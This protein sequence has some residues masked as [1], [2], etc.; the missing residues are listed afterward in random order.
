[1]VSVVEFAQI[2]Q[3]ISPKLRVSL[4]ADASGRTVVKSRIQSVLIVTKARDNR[5]IKLTR[6]LAVYLMSKRTSTS[7]SDRPGSA[8]STASTATASGTNN[9]Y[10][11]NGSS[12]DRGLIVYVDAQL[13]KSKRFNAAGIKEEHPE[14]F[15]PTVRRRSS[16]STSI[17][18]ISAAAS[19]ASLGDLHRKR[20][21]MGEEGQLRYWTGEM[22]SSQPHLFDFVIT[23]GGDGTVLFTSWLLCVPCPSSLLSVVLLTLRH[24]G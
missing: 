16:S 15:R 11:G 6:E 5:L 19:S 17:S 14:F 4:K 23:L 24:K 7:P 12:G 18:T 10:S 21:V 9:H 1:M 3:T 20:S 2:D 8:A 22:C 13:R